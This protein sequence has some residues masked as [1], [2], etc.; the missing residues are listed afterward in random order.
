MPKEYQQ[1]IGDVLSM[2][3]E[4]EA[5][6]YGPWGDDLAETV[7]PDVLVDGETV[8]TTKMESATGL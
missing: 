3:G 7:I 4:D 8:M 6:L 5:A 2:M 1:K